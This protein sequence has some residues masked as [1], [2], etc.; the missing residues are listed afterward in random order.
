MSP[1][2]ATPLPANILDD[3]LPADIRVAEREKRLQHILLHDPGVRTL[4]LARFCTA[5]GLTG[6]AY[7]VMVYLATTGTSQAIISVVGAV[8]F[9]A[10]LLFGLGAACW[11][12]PSPAAR[13]W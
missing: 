13:R 4:I 2:T 8:R 10:A 1:M 11:Q 12:A 7:G 6:L 3:G 9:L 5:L